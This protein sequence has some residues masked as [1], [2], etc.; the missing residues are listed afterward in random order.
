MTFNL[1]GGADFGFLHKFTGNPPRQKARLAEL[2]RLRKTNLAR[3]KAELAHMLKAG[4]PE[5]TFRS[6]AAW[7]LGLYNLSA[8]DWK[9]PAKQPFKL[10]ADQ[11]AGILTHPAWLVVERRPL[12]WLKP[13]VS[14]NQGSSPQLLLLYHLVRSGQS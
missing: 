3:R 11:R 14:R 13:V 2:E 7:Y 10:P 12:D 8:H 5:Q 1:D 9:W 4:G 6:R